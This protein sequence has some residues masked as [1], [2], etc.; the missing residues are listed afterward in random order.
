MVEFVGRDG[1]RKRYDFAELAV[2]GLREEL[3]AAF[4]VRVGVTG[5]LH[6][7]ASANN[8]WSAVRRFTAFLA[9]VR[10]RPDTPRAITASHLRRFRAQRLETQSEVAVLAEMRRVCRVLMEF[11]DGS[12]HPDTR[13]YLRTGQ[14]MVDPGT[15]RLGVPGYSDELFG[16]I[17]RAAR[18]DVGRVRDRIRASERLLATHASQPAAL[19][20]LEA[21]QGQEVAELVALAETGEV[22]DLRFPTGS[23]DPWSRMAYARRLFLVTSDLAPLMVLGVGLSGRNGGTVKELPAAHELLDE[24]AVQLQAV[25]RRRGAGHWYSDVVWEIG[26]P[27]RQLHTPG[28]FYLLLLELTARSRA[29]SG[30][31]TAWSIWVNNG[32]REGLGGGGHVDPFAQVLSRDTRL[33]HWARGHGLTENDVPLRLTMNRLKTTVERRTTRA[34]GG[35]LPSAVRTNTQDVL[36]T[37]YLAGDPTVRDWA[38]GVVAEALTDAE[39][40]AREAHRRLLNGNGGPIPVVTSDVAG[41]VDTR[42]AA[43]AFAACTSVRD[44]P[45][46][47]GVCRASFLACF[48]CRNAVVTREHL[49]GLVD[50]LGELERRWTTTGRDDWWRRY[51]Q[52]WLSVTEDIL[53]TF[54][55]AEVAAAKASTDGRAANL[56]DLLEGPK[57]NG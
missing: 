53:P 47:D 21:G 15:G 12:L 14:I 10:P 56:L 4:A 5:T 29:F 28:G 35:H 25:K 50:L 26:Q 49:P 48:A 38:E 23:P 54:T 18:S 51:G 52:A 36:F 1:R 55:P 7:L 20:A 27:S 41:G 40:S 33:S 13:A 46:N 34:V 44:S 8:A 39:D 24:R 32:V 3:A 19:E 6:T 17:M 43:T 57:E 16:R 30:S 9:T 45:F 31:T 42:A 11:P 22:P 2:P 37:S